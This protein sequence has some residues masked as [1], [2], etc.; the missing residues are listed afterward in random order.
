MIYIDDKKKLNLSKLHETQKE[1]I[2]STYL[3]T[4]IVGGYQSGKSTAAC[5]KAITHLLRFPSVPIA[6]Y[7]PT[8]GLFDDMLIPKLRNL[9][10]GI[11]IPFTHNQ[12][13]AKIVTP[14]G[15]IWMRSMDYPDR[16]VSYSVGYS[17]VD[18]VDVV[19]PNK[20]T[21]AMK[22]ISSRNSFKKGSPNQ[23]DFVSTPEGFAYMYDFFIKKANSNKKLLRLSTLDNEINLADGYIQ[24]LREHY[25]AD[26]LEAYLNGEFVNLES[27]TC[28]YKFDRN[29]NNTIRIATDS[30]TLYVGMDFNVGNMHAVINVVDEIPKAV[31]ELTGVYDTETMCQLL[32]DKYPSNKII[33]Y[34]DASG[35]NRHTNATNTDFDILIEHGFKYKAPGQNPNVKDRI[36][37]TNR[38]FMNGNGDVGF[39]VNTVK[40]PEY[41]EALE[42]M[43]YNKNGLPDKTSGFDHITEA[44]DYFLYYEYSTQKRLDEINDYYSDI[45][46]N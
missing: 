13:K 41:T 32:R 5:V 29:I 1:F 40:C 18:E 6:Y 20:R 21:D 43:P 14:Y 25:T 16:I 37:N 46:F 9:F 33:V 36:K 17:I 7:L 23:I 34:P 8:Y 3:H 19:H 30:D 44:N 45:D 12:S 15:E 27:G 35:K 24:G 39:K 4:G 38:L 22:R 11:N 31:D 26:Q 28:Y 2:K 10:E 42:R